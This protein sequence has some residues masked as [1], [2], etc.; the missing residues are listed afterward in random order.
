MT[1]KNV[2]DEWNEIDYGTFDSSVGVL[3]DAD[4]E[5]D[6]ILLKLIGTMYM[7]KQMLEEKP[8]MS[9]SGMKRL[10]RL[11][12]VTMSLQEPMSEEKRVGFGT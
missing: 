4:E 10:R 1:V 6:T 12:S 9:P 3:T 11:K 5:L 8:L 2:M 7:V